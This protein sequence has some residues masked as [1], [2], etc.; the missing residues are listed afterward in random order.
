MRTTFTARWIP[1][2]GQ[3]AHLG[4]VALVAIQLALALLVI[5][6]YQLESR[7]FFNVMVLGAVGFIVHAL[8]P[9]RYRLA[10]FALLSLASVAVAF[11]PVDGFFVV[12]L[13][14]AL[15]GI[16]HLRAPMSVRVLLLLGTAGLFAVWRM[17]LL[18]APWSLAIWP[19]VGSMFMFRLAL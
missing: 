15:I 16:C 12:V 3:L 14:L 17:E 18:P 7:T 11:G 10:F 1:M 9:L 6:R 8:L 19:I 5:Q 2:N 13:G 4:N